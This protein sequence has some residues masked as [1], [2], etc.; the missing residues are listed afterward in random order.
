MDTNSALERTITKVLTQAEGDMIAQLDSAYEQAVNK[1]Q[2]SRGE[3]DSDY[4]KIID[5]ARKQA[6]NLKRQMIGSSRLSARNRQLLA[7]EDA[8][9]RAFEKARSEIDSVRNTEKYASMTKK[10]LQESVSAVGGDTVVECN[11]KDRSL[12]SKLVQELEHSLKV[13][14]SISKEPINVL[15]GVRVRSKDGSM[16]FENT[17]D[18][19]IERLKPL[20]KKDIAKLFIG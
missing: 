2:S 14:M 3:V 19:R 15:G 7:I 11:E 17:L 6:E 13:R 18:S 20:I 8:V 4:A 10:L 16:V 12:V 1:L 9:S 5:V